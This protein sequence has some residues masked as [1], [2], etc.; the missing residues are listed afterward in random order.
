M[1]Q[2]W[3]SV[4]KVICNLPIWC[5]HPD[6]ASR[7]PCKRSCCSSSYRPPSTYL[8][9][10]HSER[11]RPQGSPACPFHAT[12]GVT[13][14][15]DVS[16]SISEEE[17]LRVIQGAQEYQQAAGARRGAAGAESDAALAEW[18]DSNAASGGVGGF[19]D[20]WTEIAKVCMRREVSPAQLGTCMTVATSPSVSSSDPYLDPEQAYREG[21]EG[22]MCHNRCDD[23]CPPP[24]PLPGG[25]VQ[26]A[27][28][29]SAH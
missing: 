21:G 5:M 23:L 25:L 12:Q 4:Q 13:F 8:L 3:A 20:S 10:S 28:L 29:G 19:T 18:W 6:R 7:T 24:P 26:P 11:P 14:P 9:R 16:V 27:R 2:A 17:A 15:E 1:A 22:S